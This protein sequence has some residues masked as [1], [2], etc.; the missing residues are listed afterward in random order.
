MSKNWPDILKSMSR[1][2][3]A[4][5]K[6]SPAVMRAFGTLAGA[7]TEDGALD[8]KTKELM[9]VA[10]SVVIRCDGCIAYHT[11]AAIKAGATRDEAVEAIG[12]AVEMGGGP[13]SVY[14]GDALDAFDQLAAL[15]G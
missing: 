5:A 9:A 8:H 11:Y 6:A 7:A 15:G 10:I 1:N 13:A 2:N 14:G 4:L 3:T 12:V